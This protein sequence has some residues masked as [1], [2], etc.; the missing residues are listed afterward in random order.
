MGG[1]ACSL[2]KINLYDPA[3]ELIRAGLQRFGFPSLPLLDFTLSSRPCL[4]PLFRVHHRLVAR[5]HGNGAVGAAAVDAAT[6][7]DGSNNGNNKGGSRKGF[8]A[9]RPSAPQLLLS[10]SLHVPASQQSSNLRGTSGVGGSGGR[11]IYAFDGKRGQNLTTA[12]SGAA[13]AAGGSLGA[14][15][16]VWG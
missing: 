7:H 3:P 15:R 14:R 1:K 11:A 5:L 10:H 8:G 4:S 6:Y 2:P 16:S 12:W 13:A 9:L